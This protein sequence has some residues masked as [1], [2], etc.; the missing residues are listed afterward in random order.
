MSEPKVFISHSA[1][2][3]NKEWL[4][5]FVYALE[6]QGFSVWLDES[7]LGLGESIVQQ[8]DEALR[9]SDIIV[10]LL[11][12]NAVKNPNIF[13]EFG[14]A[15]ATGKVVVPIVPRDFNLS[16]LP[17]PLK[18]RSFLLRESPEETAIALADLAKRLQVG[19]DSASLK[20]HSLSDSDIERIATHIINYLDANHFT[21]VSFDRVRERINSNYSDELLK[22]VID[23]LPNRF[24]RVH[25]KGNRPG[26]GLVQET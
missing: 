8:I 7:S 5:Q 19:Q 23:K 4:Q 16:L 20:S 21:M 11:D 6:R 3:S 2:H 13:F 15:V 9:S 1:S 12:E 14:V 26:I 25:L 24:R 22:E 10:F 18:S 17:A